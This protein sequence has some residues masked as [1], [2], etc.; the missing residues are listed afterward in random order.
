M[1][2]NEREPN[3]RGT[4]PSFIPSGSPQRRQVNPKAGGSTGNTPIPPSFN[5]SSSKRHSTHHDDPTQKPTSF[6]PSRTAS[7]RSPRVDAV[8]PRRTSGST[9]HTNAR[10]GQGQ[11]GNN[12]AAARPASGRNPQ[13]VSG[14]NRGSRAPLAGTSVA[15][16]RHRPFRAFLV[17]VAILLI[18][19]IIAVF[20]LWHW[21]DSQ[22]DKS[23]WLTSSANTPGMAW[24]ILGSDQRDEN[25]GVGGSASDVPGTRTDSILVLTRA[26]NG[27]GSLIS[28]PRDS[29]VQVNNQ[30]M[31]VNAVSQL[32]GRQSLVGEIEDITGER[33][34]HVAQIRFDG[35]E[36]VVDALGGVELCYDANVNDANSGLVWT[37]G[38]HTANGGT[39]LAFSRMRYSDP[40]GDFGRSLRQ[41]QLIAAIMKK[42]SSSKVLTNPATLNKVA[43]AS[44]A[45]VTVD[46]NT[47]PY[48][49][50]MMALTLRGASGTDG[51]N[52]SVYWSNPGYYVNG[53]GSTVLLDEAKNTALFKEL[54]NGTHAAGTVGTL[55]ES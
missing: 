9:G 12:H 53:V 3:D 31:K 1:S 48:T 38:C 41:R 39:A 25:G 52:G 45:A 16:R 11:R 29:L 14:R 8:A 21:M 46:E 18:A 23:D 24:L 34:D 27:R 28:I 15:A 30:Y 44:L 47:N 42:S 36:E 13:P 17:T 19:A 6:A 35:L 50:L 55:A 20:G 40:Q 5:P 10:T 54:M 32:I 7:Q 26:Q 33:I 2:G 4:P 51:V 37:K 49:L 43:K 22:L